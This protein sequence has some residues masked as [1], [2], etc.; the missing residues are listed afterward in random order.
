MERLVKLLA[1]LLL[2]VMGFWWGVRTG[3]APVRRDLS[4]YSKAQLTWAAEGILE[5]ISELEDDLA[6]VR[7][8]MEQK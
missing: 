8:M 2:L 1:A 5:Q 4:S 3:A 7:A 6:R